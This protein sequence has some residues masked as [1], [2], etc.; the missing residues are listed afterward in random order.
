MK[1]IPFVLSLA[2]LL[3]ISGCGLWENRFA[4]KEEELQ[5]EES[6]I[7]ESF[8][9]EDLNTEN[10]DLTSSQSESGTTIPT[11]QLNS[12][13]I[14]IAN[15]IAPSGVSDLKEQIDKLERE[16]ENL[17][18]LVSSLEN[19]N[20]SAQDIIARAEKEE[21]KFNQ[22]GRFSAFENHDWAEKLLNLMEKQRLPIY[23]QSEPKL[24]NPDNIISA[25][26][27]ENGQIFNFI[28]EE[29]GGFG[30]FRYDVALNSLQPAVWDNSS[31]QVPAA[32]AHFGKRIGRT[33]ELSANY[34]ENDCQKTVDYAY[35]FVKNELTVSKTCTRCPGQEEQCASLP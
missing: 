22:C 18:S 35:E 19:T 24:V 17:K 9:A 15:T 27:S 20:Q 10:T 14:T 34:Q 5:A 32:P 26:F 3:T 33:I 23:G 28:V 1:K 4:E 11:I 7:E 8:S 16:N 21:L 29:D 31:N 6:L 25:C 2:L 13:G 30:V 12:T